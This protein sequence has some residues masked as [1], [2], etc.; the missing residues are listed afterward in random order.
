MFF[1]NV[2]DTIIPVRLK[3]FY[4]AIVKERRKKPRP[5]YLQTVKDEAH[6]T[7]HTYFHVG[8]PVPEA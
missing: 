2:L 3:S 4:K 6:Q 8:I 5:K 1:S 7:K